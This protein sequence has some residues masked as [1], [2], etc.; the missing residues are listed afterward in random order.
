VGY[1]VL[2]MTERLIAVGIFVWTALVTIDVCAQD[3][4]RVAPTNPVAVGMPSGHAVKREGAAPGQ[5]S[6]TQLE[7]IQEVNGYFNQ[8]TS[9]KGSFVQTNADNKRL[10]GKFYILRPGRFRFDFS[11]P[12]KLVIISD[13]QSIAIQ[14]HDLKTDDRWDLG[15]TPFRA[16]F[17][18]NVDLLRDAHV[19]EV[20][21]VDDTIV[22]VFE[23]KRAE[24]ASRIKLFL[25][26]KPTLQLKAWITKDMQ[27]YDTRID[28][29]D[30]V[31][32]DNLDASLFNPAA[33]T[34]ERLR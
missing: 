17:Q 8:I 20:Q 5:L 24:A 3:A 28:L 21:Q 9:L 6:R 34:F 31:K 22:V 29:N 27:G 14:D 1:R 30:A 16:L 19:F 7:L 32:A 12:S 4:K 18:K 15:Y 11:P 10:R 25:A 26:T 33:V 13:G 2:I 23:D